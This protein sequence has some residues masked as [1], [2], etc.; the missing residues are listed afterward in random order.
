MKF[1]EY[2]K[3]LAIQALI[4]GYLQPALEEYPNAEELHNRVMDQVLTMVK[5]TA[6]VY[7]IHVP[8]TG[9]APPGYNNVGD[10]IFKATIMLQFYRSIS[11][12]YINFGM[13]A[14]DRCFFMNVYEFSPHGDD[15]VA[16]WGIFDEIT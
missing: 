8:E 12:F 13:R 5:A 6:M 3:L 1:E 16:R 11:V 10:L 7:D 4:K 15:P 14:A 2:Y 9:I